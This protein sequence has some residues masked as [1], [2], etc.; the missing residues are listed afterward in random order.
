MLPALGLSLAALQVRE[1]A[2]ITS[3][4]LMMALL[5]RVAFGVL[6]R[7]CERQADLVGAELAGDPQV[8]CDALKSVAHLSGQGED[9]PSWRHYTIAQRVAFLQAVRRHPSLAIWHH[10]F[11]RM[12]RHSLILIIITL[13]LAMSYILEPRADSIRD[14]QQAINSWIQRDRD[15]GVALQATDSGLHMPLATWL[16]RLDNAPRQRFARLTLRQIGVDMGVD[17]EGDPRF[18]DRPIYRWRH[19]LMAFQD[20]I[21]GDSELDHEI[22][23]SLAYGLVAGTEKPTAMDLAIARAVLPRL[24]TQAADQKSAH[25]LLDTIGCVHFAL[26]EYAKAVTAFEM[27]MTR[28]A[29]DTTLTNVSWLTSEA[30]RRQL[31]KIHAHMQSLYSRRL[32]AARINAGKIAGGTSPESPDLL[33]LPRDLGQILPP[34]AAPLAPVVG[35]PG[36]AGI[37]P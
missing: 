4:L 36:T 31:G 27:V 16:N 30:D 9:E 2:E 37:I 28:F 6:S 19:R 21:T 17:K 10:K 22:D 14:P 3:I 15:L 33:P 1:I 26:G 8:M 12:M 23:N 25:A 34:S 7:A 29:A 5:W 18:D 13:L 32:D 35:A 11:V 24:I 20:V